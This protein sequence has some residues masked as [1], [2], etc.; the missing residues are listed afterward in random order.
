MDLSA[1]MI[2]WSG[3]EDGFSH[4]GGSFLGLLCSLDPC[5]TLSKKVFAPAGLGVRECR[6]D[7]AFSRVWNV[8]CFPSG[9]CSHRMAGYANV[10]QM[11][12]L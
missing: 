10:K 12:Y 2:G 5:L 9:A 4:F 8:S 1:V 11:L 6:K 3:V 7:S